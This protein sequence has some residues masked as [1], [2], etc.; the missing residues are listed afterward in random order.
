MTFSQTWFLT[1]KN[2]RVHDREG[3]L[4]V[5]ESSAGVDAVLS[6]AESASEPRPPNGSACKDEAEK[7]PADGGGTGGNR[8]KALDM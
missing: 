8:E 1:Q 5:A 3:D 6:S 7:M 4:P 2:H